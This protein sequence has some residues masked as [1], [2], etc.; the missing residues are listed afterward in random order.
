MK[1]TNEKYDFKVFLYQNGI[2]Q[3]DKTGRTAKD[4]A[5]ILQVSQNVAD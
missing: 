5:D 3:I 4:L 1:E 2:K